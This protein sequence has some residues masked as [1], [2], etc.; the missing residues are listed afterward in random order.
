VYIGL[1]DP[2]LILID[3]MATISIGL[4]GLIGLVGLVD[5]I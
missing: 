4:I 2:E 5:L 1:L 3:S